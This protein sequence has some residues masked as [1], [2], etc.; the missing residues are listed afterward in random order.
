MNGQN[1]DWESKV[2]L[3]YMWRN[4]HDMNFWLKISETCCENML[5]THLHNSGLFG[6]KVGIWNLHEPKDG[7]K[8]IYTK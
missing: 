4:D 5:C 8:T 2:Q 7:L 6:L 1:E 3:H